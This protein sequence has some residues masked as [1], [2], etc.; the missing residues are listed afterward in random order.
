[1]RA[2]RTHGI[3][4]PWF[5]FDPSIRSVLIPA[6]SSR[7]IPVAEVTAPTA[8]Q[9]AERRKDAAPQAGILAQIVCDCEFWMSDAKVRPQLAAAPGRRDERQIATSGVVAGMMYE[10]GATPVATVDAGLRE[11]P[12][13]VDALIDGRDRVTVFAWPRRWRVGP[14]SSRRRAVASRSS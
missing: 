7:R 6:L 4:I 5:T 9:T 1:M 13:G 11:G 12:F 8:W 14:R 3:P 10:I 2:R